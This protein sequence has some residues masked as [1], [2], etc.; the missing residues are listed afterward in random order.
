MFAKMLF[1][2][3]LKSTKIK[4]SSETLV[5]KLIEIVNKQLMYSLE[6]TFIVNFALLRNFFPSFKIVSGISI[7]HETV[8]DVI[9]IVSALLGTRRTFSAVYAVAS[10]N[11]RIVNKKLRTRFLTVTIFLQFRI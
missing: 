10:H 6:L 9:D 2:P 7:R 8:F 5:A 3:S 4:R 1:D 11:P